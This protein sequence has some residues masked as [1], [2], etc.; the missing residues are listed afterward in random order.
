M[1][2]KAVKLVHQ[3]VINVNLIQFVLNVVLT[4]YFTIMLV[5]VLA[6]MNIFQLLLPKRV[7]DVVLIVK[8]VMI[9]PFVPLV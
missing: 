6:Q 1:Y 2:Q 9:I 8:L 4:F 5:K 7:I 3:I